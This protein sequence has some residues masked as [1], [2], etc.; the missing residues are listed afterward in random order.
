MSLPQLQTGAQGIDKVFVQM[1]S[2]WA[3]AINPFIN[4]A[5]NQSTIIPNVKLVTGINNV[6]PHGLAGPLSGWSI[7]RIRAA[8]TIYDDQDTNPTPQKTL[9][10]FTSANVTVDL[11]VF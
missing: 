10:L 6:I 5:Q 2:L 1:Q 3:A 8:A 11:E 4:R 9:I 7:V